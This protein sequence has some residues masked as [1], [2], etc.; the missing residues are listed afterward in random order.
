VH[1]M[2]VATRNVVDFEPTGA[3]TLNPW[4]VS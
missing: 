4:L 1:G 3:K 2:A